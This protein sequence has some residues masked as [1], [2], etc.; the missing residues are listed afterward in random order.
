MH[1]Q[2]TFLDSISRIVFG[3][4]YNVQ[5]SLHVTHF[6]PAFCASLSNPSIF[7]GVLPSTALGGRPCTRE[8][9]LQMLTKFRKYGQP[10]RKPES[11]N[12]LTPELN[13]SA[14]CCLPRFLMGN[15]I[16]KRFNERRLYKSFGVKGLTTC[17]RDQPH[18]LK[19]TIYLISNTN[20]TVFLQLT[21]NETSSK[22]GRE[23]HISLE[24]ATA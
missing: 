8:S 21:E 20:M 1:R 24:I 10:P 12:H 6:Y 22:Y 11:V 19:H 7:F 15:L 17:S 16:F 4:K 14:Q 3:A 2:L 23:I 9:S 13:P 5:I 18:F